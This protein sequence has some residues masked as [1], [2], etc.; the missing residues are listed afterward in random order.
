MYTCMLKPMIC[1]W[2]KSPC[3]A[4]EETA[5]LASKPAIKSRHDITEEFLEVRLNSVSVG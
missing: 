4:T 2:N 1:P 3:G 5:A